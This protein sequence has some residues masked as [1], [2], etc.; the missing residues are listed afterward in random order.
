MNIPTHVVLA[1]SVFNRRN[2]KVSEYSYLPIVGCTSVGTVYTCIDTTDGDERRRPTARQ[3][4]TRSASAG[5]T[6][7][8]VITACHVTTAG[9]HAPYSRRWPT[10]AA[11]AAVNFTATTTTSPS[12]TR[13]PSSPADRPRPTTAR[14][15]SRSTR[16]HRPPRDFRF[17]RKWFRGA[18]GGRRPSCRRTPTPG[19]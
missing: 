3:S 12:A 17:R 6:R 15:P 8:H 1:V 10:S 5:T 18:A 9:D 13:R 19:R 11:T 7:Y 14:R 16:T 4:R 2:R